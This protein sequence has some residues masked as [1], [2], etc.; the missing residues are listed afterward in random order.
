MRRR[1]G[2]RRARR[3][4]TV[5][6]LVVRGARGVPARRRTRVATRRARAGGRRRCVAVRAR[7]ALVDANVFSSP[8]NSTARARSSSPCVPRANGSRER[9]SRSRC[10]R[11]RRRSKTSRGSR[12]RDGSRTPTSVGT[13]SPSVWTGARARAPSRSCRGSK[14]RSPSRRT[15]SASHWSCSRSIAVMLS[16]ASISVIPAHSRGRPIGAARGVPRRARSC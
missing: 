8:A 6:P 3:A 4:R 10:T 13:R 15:W 2:E 1:T 5:R 16:R 12:R 14:T 7:P 11:R 9:R